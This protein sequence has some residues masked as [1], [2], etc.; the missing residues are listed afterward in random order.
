[1]ILDEPDRVEI[2]VADSVLSPH[3]VVTIRVGGE[4]A[5]VSAQEWSRL[6]ARPKRGPFLCTRSTENKS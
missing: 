1:M 6:I 4:V 2:Y 3:S 5:T